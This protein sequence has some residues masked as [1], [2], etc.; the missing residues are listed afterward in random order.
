MSESN[1]CRRRSSVTD[2][3]TSSCGRNYAEP[4]FQ[5]VLPGRFTPSGESSC[6]CVEQVQSTSESDTES[7]SQQTECESIQSSSE[8]EQETGV[9]EEQ[10]HGALNLAEEE[11]SDCQPANLVPSITDYICVNKKEN[12]CPSRRKHVAQRPLS[13]LSEGGVQKLR[14]KS[15]N[16]FLLRTSSVHQR[17]RSRRGVK[18]RRFHYAGDLQCA[19]KNLR[20]ENKRLQTVLD[21]LEKQSRN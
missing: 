5:F 10:L 2:T 7:T 15:K 9:E 21:W 20:L 11:D 14:A 12:Y 3:T 17:V 16:S 4:A 8:S 19:N 1:L 13:I 6:G 18:M